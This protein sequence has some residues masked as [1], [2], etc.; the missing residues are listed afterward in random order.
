VR[1]DVHPFRHEST[2]TWS[3]VVADPATNKA[4]IIDPVL[5]FDP[6]SGR[7]AATSAEAIAA[8]LRERG[9]ACEWIL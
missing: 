7:S 9:L 1:P 8:F 4:A 5:D 2:G 6:K 3:Y